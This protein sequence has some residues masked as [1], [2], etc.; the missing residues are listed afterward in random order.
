MT[1]TELQQ[2]LAAVR[3]GTVDT[4]AASAAIL[5]VLRAAPIEDLGFARVDMHRELCVRASRK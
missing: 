2:L 4:A 3:A 1:P 5:D